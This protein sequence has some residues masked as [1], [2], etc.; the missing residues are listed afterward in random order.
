MLGPTVTQ[1][2]R[3]R[4]RRAR[5]ALLGPTV[6]QQARRRAVRTAQWSGRRWSTAGKRFRPDG[7][8]GQSVRRGCGGGL[9]ESGYATTARGRAVAPLFMHG[10]R[11]LAAGGGCEPTLWP[12]DGPAKKKGSAERRVE[13]GFWKALS[14][15]GSIFE[16]AEKNEAN[17]G[18][19]IAEDGWA[20]MGV[21]VTFGVSRADRERRQRHGQLDVWTA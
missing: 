12:R 4:G 3:R 13:S 9:A 17:C 19:R 2:A 1:Q 5:L 7:G 15:R 16:D 14:A 11:R 10:W 21:V 20:G 6:T 18:F 8:L